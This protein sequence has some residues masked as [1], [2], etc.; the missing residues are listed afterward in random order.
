MSIREIGEWEIARAKGRETDK[1]WLKKREE[2]WWG[3][4]EAKGSVL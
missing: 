1:E 4:Q 2:H 3:V